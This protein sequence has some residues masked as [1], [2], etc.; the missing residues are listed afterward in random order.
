M[1]A[2]GEGRTNG[3]NIWLAD[4]AGTIPSEFGTAVSVAST[5]QRSAFARFRSAIVRL[6]GSESCGGAPADK[7][8]AL[9]LMLNAWLVGRV[10][11]Y[12]AILLVAVLR[13]RAAADGSEDFQRFVSAATP[14]AEMI[15]AVGVV[16]GQITNWS[17]VVFGWQERTFY[18]QRLAPNTNGV[19]DPWIPTSG[20]VGASFTHVWSIGQ[21]GINIAEKTHSLPTLAH[22]N[23]PMDLASRDLRRILMDMSLGL[24]LCDNETIEWHGRDSFTA[25]PRQFPDQPPRSVMIEGKITAHAETGPAEI[26]YWSRDAP[27][28]TNIVRYAYDKSIHQSLPHRY[29]R[30]ISESGK[31]E[32]LVAENRILRVDTSM[33][34]LEDTGGY[35]PSL[36]AAGVSRRFVNIF[37]NDVMY[38]LSADGVATRIGTMAEIEY[39]GISQLFDK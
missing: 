32:R 38:S 2:T 34:N 11:T 39:K 17:Y 20:I 27:G 26:L 15:H 6:I 16:R 21:L 36:F 19:G 7:L 14:V 28:V 10:R 5:R 13:S 30:S 18:C 3:G 31:G 33:T 37:T 12:I 1:G 9:M 25:R 8:R 23:N 35:V 4:R 24:T 29:W 22:I